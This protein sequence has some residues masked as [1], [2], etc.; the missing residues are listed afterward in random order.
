MAKSVV[1]HL[2]FN[3][4][5]PSSNPVKCLHVSFSYIISYCLRFS[6]PE[7]AHTVSSL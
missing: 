1:G 2:D 5:D 3:P 7:K 6:S 4:S